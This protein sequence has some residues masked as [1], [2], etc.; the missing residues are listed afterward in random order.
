MEI[1]LL[2]KKTNKKTGI[3]ILTS[4]KVDFRTR[5]SN[6]DKMSHFIVR[7]RSFPRWH[8]HLKLVYNYPQNIKYLKQ[9]LKE[10]QE[11]NRS[12][13]RVQSFKIGISEVI[14]QIENQ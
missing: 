1:K 9:K 8:A 7:N 2:F 5:N 14:E 6:R 12:T 10:L 4:H 11:I 3:A 13:V